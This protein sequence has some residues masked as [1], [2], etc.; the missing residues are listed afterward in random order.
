MCTSKNAFTFDT[1]VYD[2]VRYF[3][4]YFIG[5]QMFFSLAFF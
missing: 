5:V 3:N 4:L 2:T 1:P